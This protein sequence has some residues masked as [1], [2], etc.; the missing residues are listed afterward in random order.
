[1][2]GARLV[3]I[4]RP[5]PEKIGLVDQIEADS[6]A[7]GALAAR[8]LIAA[9]CSNVAVVLS[10]SRTSAKLARAEAFITVMKDHHV[11]VTQWSRGRNTYETG[12][13]AAH[14]LLAKPG[15]DGIFG[16]TDEIALGVMN[17]ARHE[18]GLSVPKDVSVIGFDD[19]PISD[20]SSHQLTTVSQS[21]SSLTQATLKAITGPANAPSSHHF[22]PVRL[23]ERQSVRPASAAT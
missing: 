15:T 19:A 1:A 21:L 14:G 9:G 10:G 11:P 6:A 18:L 23:V 5:L 2:N 8:R 12:V 20:W 17:T 3:L 22:I 13:E 16:V 7:G 4:N